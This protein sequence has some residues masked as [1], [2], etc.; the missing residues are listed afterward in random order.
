MKSF[1]MMLSGVR[2]DPEYV[3]AWGHLLRLQA[4]VVARIE[5]DLRKSDKIALTWY[6]VLLTLDNTTEKRLRMSEI[7]E[8]IVLSR[9]AL[10]RSVDRLEAEGF[11][12]RERCSQD[13]R[14]AYAVLTKK[15][16]RALTEA[17]RVYWA[18]IRKHFASN[19]TAAEISDLRSILEGAVTRFRDTA[20]KRS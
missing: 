11:L 14:G 3:E 1:S 12:K 19:M 9:S 18:G 7:A 4:R 5:A 6:D 2:V 13:E 16:R 20:R 15:G 8:R 10:T 17:R